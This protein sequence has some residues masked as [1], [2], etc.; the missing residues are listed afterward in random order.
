M[1]GLKE[2]YDDCETLIGTSPFLRVAVP[3]KP[4]KP[5]LYS[6]TNPGGGSKTRRSE[7]GKGSPSGGATTGVGG[8]RVSLL[9]S[10]TKGKPLSTS[11]P[12]TSDL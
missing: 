5:F 4:A 2:R 6:V 7:T 9:P 3:V 11:S 12:G 8:S 1:S 10:A